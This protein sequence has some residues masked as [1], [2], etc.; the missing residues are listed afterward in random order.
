V[1]NQS[2]DQRDY[3]AEFEKVNEPARELLV[4]AGRHINYLR[5]VVR[6]MLPYFPTDHP[7]YPGFSEAA[8]G[9][10]RCQCGVHEWP[11]GTTQIEG[12]DKSLH[13]EKRECRRALDVQA[14]RQC[15]GGGKCP[16]PQWCG[17]EQ[18][19]LWDRWNPK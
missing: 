9:T 11:S 15:K 16:E 4:D 7:Y 18:R 3:L 12:A 19:C 10:G 2:A 13:Y 17:E 8:G 14:E 5:T 6:T 1:D